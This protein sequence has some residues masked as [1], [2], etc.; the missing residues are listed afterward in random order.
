[1]EIKRL[2]ESQRRLASEWYI[3]VGTGK[4]L[5]KVGAYKYHSS[6]KTAMDYVIK[7][8]ERD[9]KWKYE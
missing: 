3:R 4:W 8:S 6:E 1:M 7:E 9:G 2:K 5:S